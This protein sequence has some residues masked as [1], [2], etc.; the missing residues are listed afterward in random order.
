MTEKI[1]KI[2]VEKIKEISPNSSKIKELENLSKRIIDE[3]KKFN[4]NA[5]IGGSLAK[6]TL[7]KK[8]VQ[9]I[10]IFVVFENE[11]QIKELEKIISKTSFAKKTKKVHG[12]RDYFQIDFG[13]T[14]IEL[15]PTIKINN[16]IPLNVTDISLMHTNYIISKIKENPKIS[17]EIKLAK[18][19]CYANNF[20]G[21]ESYL[22]GFSGYSLEVLIIH[23]NGFLN[24]LKKINKEKIIDPMK[25]YKNKNQVYYELNSAKTKSPL[26][27]IDPTYKERNIT[28]GLSKETFEKFLK[29]KDRFLKNPSIVFFEP[30]K[31]D[32][33][34]LKKIAKKNKAFLFKLELKTNR[35]EGDIAGTKMKK[36]FDFFCNELKRNKQE[37]LEKEF[38]YP[39]NKK[40]AEAYVIIKENHLIELKGPPI[41]MKEAVN[42]FKEQNKDILI[43]KGFIWTKKKITLS[44]IFDNSNKVRNE[45]GAWIEGFEKF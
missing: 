14:K 22:K 42:A 5:F 4:L 37:L 28:A 29:I 36:F 44:E 45:I 26:I 30:Q 2:L 38:Y 25:Y 12:S 33:E 41:S 10:D 16:Q 39:G 27:V 20:Y 15:I 1:K 3:L 35:Q 11:N 34:I 24:F 18:T 32:I 7:I 19:F 17:D 40:S 31:I 21:A 9:D 43:K 13:Q 6:K 8:E 23:F